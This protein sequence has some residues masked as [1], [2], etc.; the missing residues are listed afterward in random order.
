MRLPLAPQEDTG[1]SPPTT[2][3]QSGGGLELRDRAFATAGGFLAA[4]E[5]TT[6]EPPVSEALAKGRG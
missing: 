2:A 5:A 6:I 4:D 3:L 1:R